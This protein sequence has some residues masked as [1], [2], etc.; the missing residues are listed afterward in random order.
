[1]H[2]DGKANTTETQEPGLKAGALGKEKTGMEDPLLL[3]ASL[4]HL[5]PS[6]AHNLDLKILT[7]YPPPSFPEPQG[8]CRRLT[9]LH[10]TPE[11]TVRLCEVIWLQE[12]KTVLK[13]RGPPPGPQFRA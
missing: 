4:N 1:M 7:P 11:Q 13:L 8:K 3:Q 2:A 6:H 12:R 9:N 5:T 10:F